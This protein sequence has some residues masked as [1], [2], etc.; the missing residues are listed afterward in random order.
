MKGTP[1]N[2]EYILRVR[3][4]AR[5]KAVGL[6]STVAFKDKAKYTRKSK[7]PKRHEG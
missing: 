6:K 3:K 1:S 4:E 5:R 2:N 7:H